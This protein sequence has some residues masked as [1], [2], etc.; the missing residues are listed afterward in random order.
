M[1]FLYSMCQ[2]NIDSIVLFRMILL[3]WK[4]CRK[5]RDDFSRREKRFGESEAILVKK[6]VINSVVYLD[7]LFLLALLKY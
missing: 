6:E 1:F 2:K 7:L 3:N 4:P 5:T